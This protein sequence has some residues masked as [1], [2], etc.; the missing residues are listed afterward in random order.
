MLWFPGVSEE[1]RKAIAQAFVSHLVVEERDTME[2]TFYVRGELPADFS[3]ATGDPIADR[4]SRPIAA[5][6][7]RANHFGLVTRRG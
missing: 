5:L 6:V 7:R 3:G 1:R 2:P 4:Y